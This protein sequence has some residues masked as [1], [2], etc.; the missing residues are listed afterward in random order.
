MKRLGLLLAVVLFVSVVLSFSIPAVACGSPG[1]TACVQG[2]GN[3]A[4]SGYELYVFG[5]KR[6]GCTGANQ[7]NGESCGAFCSKGTL[8]YYVNGS[9]DSHCFI[10]HYS[11]DPLNVGVTGC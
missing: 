10:V 4:V 2:C 3:L 7:W 11:P 5:A 1:E 6:V 8:T 9:Q